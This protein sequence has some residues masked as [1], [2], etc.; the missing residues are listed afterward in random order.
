MTEPMTIGEIAD[1][2]GL[3]RAAVTNWR[4]RHEDFPAPH[5]SRGDEPVFAPD[6]LAQWLD[7]RRVPV[8]A[9]RD[10]EKPGQTFGDRFRGRVRAGNAPSGAGEPRLGLGRLI[11][12]ARA[13]G[14]DARYALLV[15]CYLRTRADD[16][17]RLANRQPAAVEDFEA[18]VKRHEEAVPGLRQLVGSVLTEAALSPW[19]ARAIRSLDR[20]TAETA[21]EQV[22][23]LLD[24]PDLGQ[25]FHT[26]LSLVRTMLGLMEPRAGESVRD[27]VCGTGN[28]LIEAA[29]LPG[30]GAISGAMGLQPIWAMAKLHLLAHG[31]DADLGTGPR[32]GLEPRPAERADV[33][34]SNPPFGRRFHAGAHQD[35]DDHA[36]RYGSPDG[37]S[38][39]FAW[40]Q[41]ILASLTEGGRAAVVVPAGAAFRQGADR[42]IREAMV[43]DGVV[44][45]VI[46]LPAGL[47]HTTGIKVSVW[48]LGPG[49]GT[50]RDVLMFDA[51][52]SS[53]PT[54]R[55]RREL[56]PAI[57]PRIFA[58]WQAGRNGSADKA[59]LSRMVPFAE[60]E[61]SGFQLEPAAYLVA[62]EATPAKAQRAERIGVVVD[63]LTGLAE[64]A[65]QA[66]TTVLKELRKAGLWTR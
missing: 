63:R 1:A 6:R 4:R 30:L 64:T 21:A 18:A 66:D 36:W 22:T 47:F 49:G 23:A 29:R 48:L 20:I 45:G 59:G 5:G 40:L 25:E 12:D 52:D 51:S 41:T 26:P 28:F 33:V 42:R 31:I 34:M 17:G 10:G 56:D 54:G 2:L 3:T 61:A 32:F 43:R 24:S 9:L 60:I 7:T 35:L 8:N 55:V 38:P 44:H 57:V 46:A 50:A 58:A 39:V 19:L 13:Y 37:A 27:P 15:L 11:E 14:F 62:R 65:R 53:V 16:W